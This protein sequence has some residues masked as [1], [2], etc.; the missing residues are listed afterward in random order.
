MWMVAA[1]IPTYGL[2]VQVGW[3][4][5]GA[6]WRAVCIHQ[7]NLVNSRTINIF[8]AIIMIALWNRADH[9]IFILSF[10]LSFFFS[11]LA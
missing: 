7:M 3:L 8:R 1:Y 5:G 2:T 11:F 6:T 9:Y 10:V 4:A